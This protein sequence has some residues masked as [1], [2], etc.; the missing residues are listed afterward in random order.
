MDLVGNW[1]YPTQVWIGAGRIAELPAA[2][3]AAGIAN[4]LL[5]TDAMLV[6]LP[7][8][9]SAVANLKRAGFPVGLFSDVQGNPVEA[10][11]TAGIAAL[12]VGQH[13]GVIAFGGGSALDVGKVIAFAARQVR[14]LWDFEDVGDQWTRADAAVILPVVAVPTTAGTGSE[15]GRAAVI[16]HSGSQTKKVIF[17]PRMLPSVAICDPQ[18]TLAL[19]AA[20]TAAT[21]IDAFIHCLE[22]YCA[23]GYHPLADGIAIEGM[24]LVQTYLPR[25]VS[26]GDDLE[27]RT[28]MMAAAAMGATAF[29]KGLG[30]VHALSHAVGALYGT[31]HGLTNGV[32]LP[33]VLQH[34]RRAIEEKIAQLAR[35]LGLRGDFVGFFEFVLA[36]RSRIGIPQRLSQLGVDTRQTRRIARMALEDP[37]A[38]GNPIP[39]DEAAL[40]RLFRAA[41]NGDLVSN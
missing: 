17:H 15:V 24:R 21:G 33:Y 25:A 16:T 1:N 14:P 27:A 9:R 13:D 2:C 41:V 7:M 28:Q 20:V 4:P 38:A 18:L 5:V 11:V 34:N 30:G 29:Q 8:I 22:A 39:L 37:T 26:S 32:I 31:H 23:P 10:N 36:L 3:F 35:W 12:A 19:P 6:K 40:Q